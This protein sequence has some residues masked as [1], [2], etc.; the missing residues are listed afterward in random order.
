MSSLSLD[1]SDYVAVNQTLVF[2]PDRE[3]TQCFDV[4]IHDDRIYERSEVFLLSLSPLESAHIS[5]TNSTVLVEI[6]DDEGITEIVG[7]TLMSLLLVSIYC[8]YV[9]I[10]LWF[11]H[12]CVCVCVDVNVSTFRRL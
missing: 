7:I 12:A 6:L 3:T 5:L 10:T 2:A 1:D 11:N 8:N 4:S 9:C